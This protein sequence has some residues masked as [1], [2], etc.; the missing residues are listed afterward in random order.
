[1]EGKAEFLTYNGASI[2]FNQSEISNISGKDLELKS[3]LIIV[4][5]ILLSLFLFLT[6]FIK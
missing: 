6:A 4:A 1:M 2:N 5:M 3:G